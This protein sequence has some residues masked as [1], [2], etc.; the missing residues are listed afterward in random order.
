MYIYIYMYVCTYVCTICAVCMYLCMYICVLWSSSVRATPPCRLLPRP[1]T[2]P[3]P[4]Y[5]VP[6]LHSTLLSVRFPSWP[7]SG[8]PVP[9]PCIYIHTY[10]H[11]YSF[12]P[13]RLFALFL[14]YSHSSS[15]PSTH[16]SILPPIQ[17]SILPSIY[18]RIYPHIS[19][20]L[21]RAEV[22][23]QHVCNRIT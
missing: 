5:T 10:I 4:A 7:W 9:Q 23:L 16:P 14:R 13:H 8:V 12:R 15:H 11:T 6:S 20:I 21:V 3:P 1:E 19:Y 2:A 18:I 17:P 22:L